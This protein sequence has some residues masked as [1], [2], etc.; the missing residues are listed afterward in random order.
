MDERSLRGIKDHLQTKEFAGSEFGEI[1]DSVGS[2][3]AGNCTFRGVSI[4]RAL[5]SDR[6]SSTVAGA[7]PE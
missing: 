1:S 7:N 3:T 2:I 4:P 6:N 5:H